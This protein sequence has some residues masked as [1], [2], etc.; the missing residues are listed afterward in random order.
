MANTDFHTLGPLQQHRCDEE[1]RPRQRLGLTPLRARIPTHQS[2]NLGNADLRINRRTILQH[3]P[4]DAGV[5]RKNRCRS[6]GSSGSCWQSCPSGVAVALALLCHN[7]LRRLR[8]RWPAPVAEVHPEAVGAVGPAGIGVEALA[9]AVH[10]RL[11]VFGK[12]DLVLLQLRAIDGA[13]LLLVDARVPGEA[14]GAPEGAA[15]RVVGG[16][17]EG[18]RIR[19]PGAQAIAASSSVQTREDLLA[20][21][22]RIGNVRLGLIHEVIG[23]DS[24]LLVAL[25]N[26]DLAEDG[27]QL[28]PR[29]LQA[30][31]RTWHA[32]R[33]R[34]CHC[35]WS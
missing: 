2:P 18:H 13:H 25:A 16:V 8:R 27:G 23:S 34:T 20:P 29:L 30:H 32:Q 17:P 33:T 7:L 6:L 12:D 10:N 19:E 31:T 24:Q 3:Q 26:V 14:G 15:D 9:G 35:L 1:R 21:L 5:L 4:Q 28:W 11:E 22:A